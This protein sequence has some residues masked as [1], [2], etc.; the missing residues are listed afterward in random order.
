MSDSHTKANSGSATEITSAA[1]SWSSTSIEEGN[2]YQPCILLV[3][4]EPEVRMSMA[5]V[6]Q[7][8]GYE[9]L[10]ASNGVE[11]LD[12][13]SQRHRE[14]EESSN[15][16]LGISD[17]VDLIIT[18]VQMP[19][20]RG[21]VL[22]RIVRERYPDIAV[23]LLTA[24]V[25]VELAV[26]SMREG[27]NDYVIKPF[28]VA[29][30]VVRIHRALERRQLL[31]ENRRYR[32]YLEQRVAEQTDKLRTLFLQSLHSLEQALEAKDFYTSNHSERVTALV[33][34]LQQRLC[35]DDTTF[36][37]RLT[38]AG[39]LHDI[40]KIALPESLLNKPGPLD[41]E[42]RQLLYRHP[43]IGNS[44]LTPIL[45][46]E[47]RAIVYH[48]HEW[49]DGSGYPKGL[50]GEEIPLGARILSVADAFDAMTSDR[51]YRPARATEEALSILRSGAGTQWDPEIVR[52]MI[53]I[54]VEVQ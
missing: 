9:T 52:T 7:R 14:R 11:A 8:A 31:L 25:D 29:D 12:L 18:D 45:D 6:L 36:A 17:P 10:Q 40:G 44:I 50:K 20:M 21:D 19:Q 22:H 13:L 37:E 3:D 41:S 15:A 43:E 1:A 48:H 34:R 4:D 27:A 46:E 38:I 54:A 39:R 5:R 32:M 49:W 24:L 23:L 26:S 53:E 33:R 42:E 35:P 28:S 2:T 47:T 30:M 51:S 16:P